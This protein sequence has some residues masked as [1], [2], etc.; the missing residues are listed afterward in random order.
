[1]YVKAVT[2]HHHHCPLSFYLV[3]TFIW[4][5]KQTINQSHLL[6]C[7]SMCIFYCMDSKLSIIRISFVLRLDSYFVFII[8]FFHSLCMCI[9]SSYLCIFLVCVPIC[10]V[11][12]CFCH[13]YNS[14]S[15]SFCAIQSI[16]YFIFVMFV[17]LYTWCV[18]I[19]WLFVCYFS[20]YVCLS[21]YLSIYVCVSLC[22][23]KMCC[24][25]SCCYLCS[26]LL[27][28]KFRYYFCHVCSLSTYLLFDVMISL[29][30]IYV[31]FE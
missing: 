9:V 2:H 12:S 5:I 31:S 29:S 24:D 14:L 1:M 13:T 20:I 15:L 8:V 23:F 4:S 21:V 19:D 28:S 3:P 30:T 17:I 16:I 7:Q 6:Y 10:H 27:C 25:K 11:F 26:Y 18:I 22:A